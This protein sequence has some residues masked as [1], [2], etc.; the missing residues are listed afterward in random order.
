MTF[1]EFQ[2]TARW[3]EDLGSDLSLDDEHDIGAKGYIYLDQLWIE[4]T[5]TW[6]PHPLR[7]PFQ[8]WYTRIGNQEYESD[9]LEVV[10]RRVFH[11]AVDLGL[12]R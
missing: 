7:A 2:S 12:T 5:E 8:K 9:T 11:F 6:E 10:E 1:E 4:S 3:S